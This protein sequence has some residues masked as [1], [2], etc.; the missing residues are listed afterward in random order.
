MTAA[1]ELTLDALV[2]GGGPAGSACAIR[3]AR[4]GAKVGLVEATDFSRFRIGETIAPS[5]RPLLS[6]LDIDD[7]D[8][9]MWSAPSSGVAAAWGQT[10]ALHR[11]SLFNPYGR[12]WRVDRRR[13]DCM[14]CDRA[15]DAGAKVFMQCRLVSAIHGS[16]HWSFALQANRRAVRGRA[17]WIVAATGRTATAPLSPSR[18]QLSL[19]RLLAIAILSDAADGKPLEYPTAALV[20]AAP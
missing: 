4:G 10:T 18:S 17:T 7:G 5:A 19:D 11:S 6:Q 20:E 14:L 16:S 15:R 9:R 1:S 13:F 12:G 3:L 8:D 2:I